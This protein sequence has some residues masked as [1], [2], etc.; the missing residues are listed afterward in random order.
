MSFPKTHIMSDDIRLALLEQNMTHIDLSL[1]KIDRGFEKL[2]DRFTKIDGR[3]DT[4]E[5]RQIN[6][7]KWLVGTM[8]GLFSGLYATFIGGMV[9]KFFHWI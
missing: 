9:A 4:L 3:L 8:F 2:D 6:N 5:D 7:F 1:I